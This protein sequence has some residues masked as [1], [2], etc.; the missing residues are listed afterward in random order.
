[1]R[2]R[3]LFHFLNLSIFLFSLLSS[4]AAAQRELKYKLNPI[5]DGDVLRFGIDLEFKGEASGTTKLVLPNRWGG[6]PN[7]YKAVQNLKVVSSNAAF[8]DTSEPHVNYQP[9]TEPDIAYSIRACAG[10]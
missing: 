7:L 2:K 5:F 4:N 8:A 6:Q 10:F 3:A 1:M 9:Q